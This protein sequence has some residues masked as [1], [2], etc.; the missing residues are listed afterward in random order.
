MAL[1]YKDRYILIF[2][3]SS[4]A[5]DPACTRQGRSKNAVTGADLPY[6]SGHH[7]E[8]FLYDTVED[9]WSVLSRPMPYGMNNMQV[10]I[11]GDTVYAVGGE[12]ATW[13][14]YNTEDV[15]MIGT[16]RRE[17]SVPRE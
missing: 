2:G 17:S 15:V 7:D 1:P 10:A 11:H 5:Y 3:G 16:I 8:V 4:H 14:N 12:P 6:W 9:T 13:L